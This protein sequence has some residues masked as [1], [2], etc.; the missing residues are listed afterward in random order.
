ML[1][2]SYWFRHFLPPRILSIIIF[3]IFFQI[4]YTFLEECMNSKKLT[5][6][7]VIIVSWKL[8]FEPGVFRKQ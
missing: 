8:G 3:L 1:V 7:S 4:N 2:L 5:I 6:L